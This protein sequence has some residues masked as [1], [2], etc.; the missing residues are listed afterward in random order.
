MYDLFDGTDRPE[1][2]T[3]SFEWVDALI[4]V[5]FIGWAVFMYFAITA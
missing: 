1:E 2:P 5:G 3:W 4:I